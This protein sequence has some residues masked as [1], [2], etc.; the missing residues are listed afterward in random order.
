MQRHVVWNVH[1]RFRVH[2]TLKSVGATVHQILV[3]ILWRLWF[4]RKQQLLAIID[5]QQLTIQ[6]QF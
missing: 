5:L 2:V 1:R 6:L 3:E 4:H